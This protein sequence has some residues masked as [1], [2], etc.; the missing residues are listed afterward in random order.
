MAPD[1]FLLNNSGPVNQSPPGP[2]LEGCVIV[3]SVFLYLWM[4]NSRKKC[5]ES[6]VT[7]AISPVVEELAVVLM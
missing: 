1:S 3:V 7:I 5:T 6:N 4:Q 2:D